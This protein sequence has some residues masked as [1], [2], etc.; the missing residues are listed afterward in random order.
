M[1]NDH[2]FE[3]PCIVCGTSLQ[4]NTIR[5]S[6]RITDDGMTAGAVEWARATIA[7]WTAVRAA[8]G[9]DDPTKPAHYPPPLFIGQQHPSLD[10][11]AEL[12][13]HNLCAVTMLQELCAKELADDIGKYVRDQLAE[14]DRRLF[15][16][17]S[18]VS[19][20]FTSKA[21]FEFSKDMDGDF[22]VP[23]VDEQKATV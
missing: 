2:D 10:H 8:V 6:V 20:R 9:V 23:V 18:R 19:V 3:L 21:G 12:A 17:V 5:I 13:A 15:V 11:V 4:P 22:Y 1:V 14:A 7:A 16:R